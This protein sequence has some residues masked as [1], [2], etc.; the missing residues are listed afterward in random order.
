MQAVGVDV[1]G[2]AGAQ[3]MAVIDLQIDR[4]AHQHAQSDA[5]AADGRA[6]Q[7]AGLLAVALD[8]GAVVKAQRAA[9]PAGVGGAQMGVYNSRLAARPMSSAISRSA[10]PRTEVAPPAPNCSPGI[11]ASLL[12]WPLSMMRACQS[13]GRMWLRLAARRRML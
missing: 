2:R 4:R 10:K 12:Y 1:I 6:A 3:H 9:V 7:F 5:D 13:R 8:V 11:S